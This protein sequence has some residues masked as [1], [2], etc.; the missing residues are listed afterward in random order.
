MIKRPGLAHFKLL[1]PCVAQP[2]KKLLSTIMGKQVYNG[3]DA[4]AALGE[5]T[6][7]QIMFRLLYLM[8]VG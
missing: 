3:W 6:K 8:V 7:I 5:N 1:R 4:A 2:C